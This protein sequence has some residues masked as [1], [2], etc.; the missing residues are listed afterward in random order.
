[1]IKLFVVILFALSC[2]CICDF[3]PNQTCCE[4]PPDFR[5][6]QPPPGFPGV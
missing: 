3:M 6:V 2:C 4:P 1:M 5:L